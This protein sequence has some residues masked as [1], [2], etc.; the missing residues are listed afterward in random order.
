MNG[1]KEDGVVAGIGIQPNGELSQMA[2]LVYRFWQSFTPS[3][4]PPSLIPMARGYRRTAR[5]RPS[6]PQPAS[7]F[8]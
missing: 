1:G 6:T 7:A 8:C 3:G 5:Y 4:P 2:R